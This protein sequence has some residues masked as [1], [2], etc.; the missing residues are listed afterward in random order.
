M[1]VF[2][3]EQADL[4]D[5]PDK[6]ARRVGAPAETQD[7]DLLIARLRVGVVLDEKLVAIANLLIE[8]EAERAAGYLVVPIRPDTLV[9]PFGLR[10][11]VGQHATANRLVKA[12]DVGFHRRRRFGIVAGTVPCPVKAQ[13]K[14]R[15]HD[16]PPRRTEEMRLFFS[17]SSRTPL[18]LLPSKNDNNYSSGNSNR[19][20]AGVR[21]AR[22]RSSPYSP[23]PPCRREPARPVRLTVRV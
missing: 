10:R 23:R 11:S 13:D 8:T 14:T 1:H 9:V 20:V 5:H 21:L 4:A 18:T 17:I 16:L 3:Q 22:W 7:I 6:A 19:A 15:R 2:R 12:H